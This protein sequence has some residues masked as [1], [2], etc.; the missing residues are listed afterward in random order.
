VN[1]PD[2]PRGPQSHA[3]RVARYWPALVLL[4]GLICPL[5]FSTW[6]TF[7]K[8]KTSLQRA[9]Q[10]ELEQI[11]EVLAN[12]LREPIWNLTPEFG[13]PVIDSVMRDSRI[14]AVH[15]TSIAQ[16]SFAEEVKPQATS[17]LIE[18]IVKPI[19]R[20]GDNIGEVVLVF[21]H[22]EIDAQLD[23]RWPEIYALG[24]VQAAL[25]FGVVVFAYWILR[26]R[27]REQALREMNQRLTGEIQ[28]RARELEAAHAELLRNESLAVLG[29]LTATVSHELRHPLGTI[30]M[31]LSL[32]GSLLQR[33]PSTIASDR[34]K[35]EKAFDRVDR[36]IDRCARIIDDLL[37]F[38]RAD[39][40][41]YEATEIDTWMQDFLA[42]FKIPATVKLHTHLESQATVNFNRER[43]RR[44][45]INL[46]S[47]AIQAM[48]PESGSQPKGE[49]T[50]VTLRNDTRVELV[51][52][53]TGD[54]IAPE[55][56]DKVFEP[57]FSTRSF[58]FGLGLPLVKQIMEQ[59][60]GGVEVGTIADGAEVL[61]W[62]PITP[63]PKT[64]GIL[65]LEAT[66]EHETQR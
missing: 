18:Q 39:N 66:V 65:Q 13:Q 16:G 34:A 55:L 40:S 23:A 60:G 17:P 9:F 33:N 58:G 51:V 8:Q 54:G 7:N 28:V 31:S 41:A 24:G 10:L 64:V 38:T 4:A 14:V 45:V 35:L 63:A 59:H 53:D 22:S 44:V 48:T 19:T 50:V 47:N 32:I 62:L 52:R 61:V 21:D 29:R 36:N 26:R 30:Q 56:H 5:V 42:E 49:L 11:S 20:N 27:E 12:G 46:L 1:S 6:Y 15:V 37:D 43:F 25:A 57:L 3:R 2:S